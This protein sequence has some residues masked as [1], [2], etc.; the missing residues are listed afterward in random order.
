MVGLISQHIGKGACS[1]SMSKALYTTCT[2]VTRTLRQMEVESQW[3][4]LQL[5]GGGVQG[6]SEGYDFA[7]KPFVLFRVILLVARY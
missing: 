2:A 4:G 6:V 5:N 7:A 1:K 3:S